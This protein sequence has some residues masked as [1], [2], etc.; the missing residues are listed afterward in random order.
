MKRYITIAAAIVACVVLFATCMNGSEGERY[1]GSAACNKCHGQ[2]HDGFQH[3]AHAFA[4]MPAASSFI[5]G[6]FQRDSNSFSF[7][8]YS[9]LPADVRVVMENRDSGFYQTAWINGAPRRSERF[10]VVIGAGRKAQSYLYW[11]G[12]QLLQLPI[13]W[14]AATH[15]WANSPGFPT[16][17]IKFNRLIPA[18]CLECHA[19][20]AT[21]FPTTE[22][23]PG[24]DPP[25]YFDRAKL[26]YG[27]GCEN[28]HGPGARHIAYH[29]QHPG[30]TIAAYIV[31]PARLSR[32]QRLDLCAA[33]HSGIRKAL[34]PAFSFQAGDTLANYFGPSPA[35]D[36]GHIEVHGNQY[37]LLAA[38]K[39]FRQ[40][41][42]EC[43]T[44]HNPHASGD[45]SLAVFSQRCMNC[46]APASMQDAGRVSAFPAPYCKRIPAKGEDIRTNCIDCHMPV[47][48]SGLVNLM[49]P[50]Q[51]QLAPLLVRTHR[52]AVY[53]APKFER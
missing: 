45:T 6:S 25:A 44:C 39:C 21:L 1:V 12:N 43:G 17:Q 42:L 38:S 13:S 32:Q 52:I 48:A 28:C 4:S 47:K 18:H 37:G 49:V 2:L 29:E 53:P 31:N 11:R 26:I 46:H 27:I 23:I 41:T 24:P 7:N 16:A 15:S 51:K 50:G 9:P 14:F 34:Q 36:T 8:D 5:K 40:S 35:V 30:D 33:C 20:T 3:T 22:T 10:G 19:T